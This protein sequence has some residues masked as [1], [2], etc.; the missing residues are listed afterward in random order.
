MSSSLGSLRS[1]GIA[2]PQGL[3]IVDWSTRLFSEAA[4]PAASQAGISDRSSS[5]TGGGVDSVSD[6][7]AAS[8]VLSS[9]YD[10][11]VN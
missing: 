7:A 10:E 6:A 3:R 1:A 2:V 9:W 11:S 4:P 8:P 5:Q